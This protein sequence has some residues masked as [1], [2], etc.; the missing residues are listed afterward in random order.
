[1]G[2]RGTKECGERV[3][4]TR[5][6]LSQVLLTSGSR[7]SKTCPVHLATVMRVVSVVGEGAERLAGENGRKSTGNCRGLFL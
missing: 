2:R 7:R 1:M 5:Q 6:R 4:G 3:S